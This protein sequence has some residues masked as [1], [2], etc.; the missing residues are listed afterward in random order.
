MDCIPECSMIQR[1]GLYSK[2][3]ISFNKAVKETY[4]GLQTI[5]EHSTDSYP[6]VG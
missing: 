1:A 3:L 2:N 6:S 4:I 5:F